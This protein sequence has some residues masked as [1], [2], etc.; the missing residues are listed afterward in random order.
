[1]FYTTRMNK[2]VIKKQV[3]NIYDQSLKIMKTFPS[4]IRQ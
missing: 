2:I 4:K 3:S 1:M